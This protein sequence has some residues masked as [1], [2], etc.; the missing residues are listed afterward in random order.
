MIASII[1]VSAADIKWCEGKQCGAILY[2]MEWYHKHWNYKRWNYEVLFLL[3]SESIILDG[4][5]ER[6]HKILCWNSR[7]DSAKYR[8]TT[9][10]EIVKFS[11]E[12]VS[13][14]VSYECRRVDGIIYLSINSVSRRSNDTVSWYTYHRVEWLL[15]VLSHDDSQITVHEAVIP[16]YNTPI[17]T[18]S[19]GDSCRTIHF[20]FDSNSE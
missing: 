20:N 12:R 15:M 11:I 7:L 10:G 1:S 13:T 8:H 6:C 3:S 14:T 19:H 9:L 18:H 5:S 4:S 17:S 2:H 16:N